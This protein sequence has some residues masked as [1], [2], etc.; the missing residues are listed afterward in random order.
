[1]ADGT[2]IKTKGRVQIRLKCGGYHGI[3]E[4]RVFLDMD[5]AMILGIPWLVKTNPHID[6]THPTVVVKEGQDWIPLPLA[7]QREDA[8]AIVLNQI[9]A[10]R[11]T[12]IFKKKELKGGF[13]GV[14]RRVELPIVDQEGQ[15]ASIVE[16]TKWWDQV[17][18]S[19]QE[20][21]LEYDDVFP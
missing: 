6:W 8:S 3:V 16:D 18:A 4:A 2:I 7:P 19:I 17:P 21:L 13:V 12:K 1:M 15:V 11:E 14:I 9:S 10:K 5:K 20:V